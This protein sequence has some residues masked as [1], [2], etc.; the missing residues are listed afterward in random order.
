M[1]KH[2][3]A[4]QTGAKKIRVHALTDGRDVPIVS[5]REQKRS[6]KEQKEEQIRRKSSL[7]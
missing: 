6:E 1:K 3:G 7:N 4:V 2:A 5:S